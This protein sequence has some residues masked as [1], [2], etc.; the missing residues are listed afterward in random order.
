VRPHQFEKGFRFDD[1]EIWRCVLFQC[2]DQFALLDAI[3]FGERFAEAA[4]GFG[5][6]P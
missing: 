1:P 2:T 4:F 5:A 6:R 3:R